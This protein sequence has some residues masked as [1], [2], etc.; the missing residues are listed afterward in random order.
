M[1]VAT[2]LTYDIRWVTEVIPTDAGLQLRFRDGS[3][4][5][6]EA[7]NPHFAVCRINA[8]SRQGRPQPVGVVLDAEGHVLDLNAAH[9]TP[10]R[11]VREIDKD[12]GHLE[13]TFW[14]YSP[15][16]GLPHDHPE[17]ERIHATL[18]E[19][20]GTAKLL[21]VATHTV[22]RVEGEP[23]QEGFI[24]AYPKIMDIRPV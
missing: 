1:P 5:F 19:A 18:A 7:V 6:L 20:A 4:A 22:E 8:E 3:S 12:R 16:C 9:D 15:A 10:V 24:P 21:C 14:A 11:H 2:K 17:F 23:E 13:V